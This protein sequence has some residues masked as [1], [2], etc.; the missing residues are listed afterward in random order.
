[1]REIGSIRLILG[2]FREILF[3]L[4]VWEVFLKEGVFKEFKWEIGWLFR[5]LVV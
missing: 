5:V 3:V 2:R 4:W 1:M